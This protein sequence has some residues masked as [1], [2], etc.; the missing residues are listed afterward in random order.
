MGN[1]IILSHEEGTNF[2]FEYKKIKDPLLK[3]HEAKNKDKDFNPQCSEKL[4]NICRVEVT[5]TIL[6]WYTEQFLRFSPKLEKI[7]NYVN[8]FNHIYNLNY[9]PISYKLIF[10]ENKVNFEDGFVIHK[11]PDGISVKGI[12]ENLER[13]NIKNILYLHGGFHIIYHY[14]SN[15]RKTGKKIG[16]HD[17]YKKIT[18]GNGTKLLDS[19]IKKHSEIEKS[20]ATLDTDQD[21]DDIFCVLDSKPIYKKAWIQNDPYLNYCYERLGKEKKV[22]TLGCSFSNDDHILEK[23]LLNHDLESLKIGVFCNN[24]R[25]NVCQAYKRIAKYPGI[26]CDI[27]ER[28]LG[29]ISFVSTKELGELLW[30]D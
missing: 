14:K 12:K 19:I 7:Q 30:K 29:K 17:L 1:G 18:A 15:P 22:L 21:Y 9:D 26:K 24:D 3:I 16:S 20:Y 27:L 8:N 23:I 6:K 4:L 11:N 25:K 10:G 28:N 2:H 13:D 5:M